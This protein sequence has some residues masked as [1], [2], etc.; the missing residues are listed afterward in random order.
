VAAAAAGRVDLPEPLKG[1]LTSGHEEIFKVGGFPYGTQ[2]CEVE[3]DPETGAVDIKAHAAIDDVGHAVNPLIVDGQTHGAIVQGVGQALMELCD[4]D[5][6]GQL[7]SA[8]FMDYAV[9]RADTVPSFVTGISEIPSPT[10]P[11]GV[12]AGGEGGTTPALAVVVN[13]IV[14]ALSDLGVTHIDMP[15]TPERVWRAIRAAAS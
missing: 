8:T 13:A 7:R 3:V 15:A 6:A 10:N 5:A 14:D 12:R 2:I 1:P 11:L 4:Y 9:P